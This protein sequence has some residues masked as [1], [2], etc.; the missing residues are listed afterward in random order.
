MIINAY[1][2]R[3]SSPHPLALRECATTI[4]ASHIRRLVIVVSD[5][6]VRSSAQIG[7]AL[8][9]LKSSVMRDTALSVALNH[10]LPILPRPSRPVD[11]QFAD[12]ISER[13]LTGLILRRDSDGLSALTTLPLSL[14]RSVQSQLDREVGR[15]LAEVD[16][17]DVE[18]GSE[19]FAADVRSSIV[20]AIAAEWMHQRALALHTP[21]GR[22]HL[23][24]RLATVPS[25]FVA[26]EPRPPE[27]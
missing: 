4:Q 18:R 14:P 25:E 24:E 16:L 6:A 12:R 15:V 26:V 1:L 3:T 7:P 11:G 19:D 10:Y 8:A 5:L 2:A 22:D 21:I 23:T 9:A 27:N 20:E 17:T 13:I